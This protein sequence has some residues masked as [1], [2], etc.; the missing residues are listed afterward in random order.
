[1]KKTKWNQFWIDFNLD[2]LHLSGIP[3]NYT[4]VASIDP[5]YAKNLQVCIL[6]VYLWFMKMYVYIIGSWCSILYCTSPG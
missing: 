5:E 2:L 1:M 6:H 3:V 4:D